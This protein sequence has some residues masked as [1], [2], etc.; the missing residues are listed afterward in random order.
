MNSIKK[1]NFFLKI[2]SNNIS[3]NNLLYFKKNI[4]PSFLNNSVELFFSLV[5]FVGGSLRSYRS[6]FGYPCKG[7]RTWSNANTMR[8]TKSI[9]FNYKYNKLKKLNKKITINKN[10]LLGEY[11]NLFWQQQWYYEW[12]SAYLKLKKIPF[13]LKK[14]NF[15]D[16]NSLSNFNIYSFYKNPLK[17]KKPHQ[18]KK[19]QPK[20]KF[21]IGFPFG[22]SFKYTDQLK[23]L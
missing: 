15:I 4:I 5:L 23:K 17:K 7:Q 12:W 3:H 20:N 13:F 22:F 8:N 10:I 19:K 14:T 2:Y 21:T 18:K 9:L 1:F 16:I 11:I 6:L